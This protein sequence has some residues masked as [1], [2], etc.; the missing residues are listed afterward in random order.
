VR[1][2]RGVKIDDE[3]ELIKI[4]RR[5]YFNKKYTKSSLPGGRRIAIR[6]RTPHVSRGK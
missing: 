6:A 2:L 4:F 5:R 3:K 1:F